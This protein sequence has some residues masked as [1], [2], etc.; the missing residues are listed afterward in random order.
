LLDG[1]THEESDVD[2]MVTGLPSGQ[3]ATAW[4]Q[5][6]ALFEAPVDLVPEEASSATFRDSVRRR[7]REITTLGDGHGT[8]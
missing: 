4:L 7:G 5:L 6:E 1:T 8:R 3:R 2:L